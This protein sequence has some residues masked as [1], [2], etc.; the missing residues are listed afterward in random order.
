ME[1]VFGTKKARETLRTKGRAHSNLSGWHNLENI[2]D[3]QIITDSFYV[4]EKYDSSEDEGGNCYDFYYVG[5][6]NRTVDN[7]LPNR[8][9]IEEGIT[10][11]GDAV[12]DVAELADEN[13]GAIMDISELLADLE[14][15]VTA[16]EGGN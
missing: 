4:L 6:H 12:M 13:S 10:E 2:N 3:C 14:E 9:K 15:R 7:F 8:E 1:Y 5:Q 11:N 16:L